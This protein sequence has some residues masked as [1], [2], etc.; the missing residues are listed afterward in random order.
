MIDQKFGA[1]TEAVVDESGVGRPPDRVEVRAAGAIL[2]IGCGAPSD[3]VPAN[4]LR[5]CLQGDPALLSSH[6]CN[7][8]RRAAE[9]VV[10]ASDV[11]DGRCRQGFDVAAQGVD[12]GGQHVVLLSVED[13]H[14]RVGTDACEAA[15]R[16]TTNAAGK[17]VGRL[18]QVLDENAGLIGEVLRSYEQLNLIFDVTR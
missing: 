5:V 16:A 6:G 13:T 4:C 15:V 10:D 2:A 3:E 17:L 12:L 1:P 14:D 9:G 18:G 7:W 8:L 11:N